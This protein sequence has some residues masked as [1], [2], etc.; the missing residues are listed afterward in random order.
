MELFV[1]NTIP[2]V[3]RGRGGEGG[4]GVGRSGVAEG[5]GGGGHVEIMTNYSPSLCSQWSRDRHVTTSYNLAFPRSVR[6]RQFNSL[7]P[8]TLLQYIV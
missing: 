5:R 8:V 3:A 2:H 7:L 4:G 1:H 6:Y